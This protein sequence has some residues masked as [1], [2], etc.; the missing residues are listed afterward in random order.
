MLV[1]FFL[2][3]SCLMV[4]LQTYPIQPH[5]LGKEQPTAQELR[6]HLIQASF[7]RQTQHGS[8]TDDVD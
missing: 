1:L 3:K 5:C 2:A 8:I 7:S 6:K 4:S